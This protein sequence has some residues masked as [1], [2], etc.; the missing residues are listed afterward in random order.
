[1]TERRN[2]EIERETGVIFGNLP[3]GGPTQDEASRLILQRKRMRCVECW[4][5]YVCMYH[6]YYTYVY[7]MYIRYGYRGQSARFRIREAFHGTRRRQLINAE[8]TYVVWLA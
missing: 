4:R 5:M 6:M 2:R 1:M 3:K 7:R 8:L